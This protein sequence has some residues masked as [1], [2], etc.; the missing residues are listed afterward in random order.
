MKYA[1]A[2]FTT[3]LF[4]ILSSVVPMRSFQ[5]ILDGYLD[6]RRYGVRLW[7]SVYRLDQADFCPDYHDMVL[8]AGKKGGLLKQL[9][10]NLH[11]MQS[12]PEWLVVLLSPSFH[13]V[14]SLSS[15]RIVE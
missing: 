7:S 2:A 5:V 3:G 1:F 4:L 14:L 12:L 6:R 11:L 9:I 13:L 8:K 10:E 15:M